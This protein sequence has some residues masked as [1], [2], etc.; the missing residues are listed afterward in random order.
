MVA[1]TSRLRQQLQP[2]QLIPTLTV[3]L[4]IGVLEVVLATSFAALIFSGS[5]AVHV[6][7]AIALMLFGA[8]TIMTLV[9]LLTSLAPAVASVQDSTAAILALIAASITAE[10]P[11]ARPETFLT[12]VA[13]IGASSILAGVIFLVLGRFGLGNLVRFIPYP[14]VGGF[15]AGTGWLL[16][17]GGAG[18]LTGTSLTMA[19]LASFGR[20]DSL[21]KWVP[22]LV[23]AVLLL[24][25]VRRYRHFLVIPGAL[26]AGLALFYAALFVGGSNMLEAETRGWLLGPFPSGSPGW[27][28]WTLEALERADWAHVFAQVAN[29]LTLLVVALLALLLNASGIEQMLKRDGDLNRELQVAGVANAAA[30]LGG[31]IIGFHALSFTA[32]ANRAGAVGRMVSLVG[33]GVCGVVLIVGTEALSLFPRAILGGLLVFL[34]LAFLVEWLY[35]AW[36]KLPRR[37]YLVIVFIVLA[38]A[39]VGLL[40]GVAVGLVAAI[41]LFVIDY[42]RTDVVRHALTGA[43]YQSRVERDP[44]DREILRQLGDE[45]HIL[46][47]QGFVFFGT[48]NS[49]LGRVRERVG[50]PSLPPVRFLVLDFRRVSGLDSSAVLSFTRALQL[51]ESNGFTL[52]LTGLRDPIRSQ[53]ARAGLEEAAGNSLRT[54]PDLDRGSQWC[55]DVVLDSV[56]RTAEA[57]Q[58]LPIQL[59][60]GLGESVDPERLMDYLDPV[61]IPAAHELI[62][63][64]QPSEDLYFLESGRLTAQ[65]TRRDGQ[66]V[67][68]R[69]MG[70]GTVVGEITMYLRTVRTASVV[71]EAPSK[72]Y[73]LT[74]SAFEE[75]ERRDPQLASAL[76]RLFARLLADRL[77][78][79]LL[80]ME[81]LRD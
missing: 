51:A 28:P 17:K 11:G 15:L 43:T 50:D 58:P 55:E 49:L 13:A 67:R 73:R 20:P 61:E 8:T 48:S 45:T 23:F 36:F 26:L 42:S 71:S 27:E 81:A 80:S 38:V 79:A 21:I 29:V 31:G 40:P 75:M 25:L 60:D 76:H 14:V 30:G 7:S 59:Q 1:T 18:V 66:T 2:R 39:A 69:T 68:L 78:D 54:F 52:V 16:F 33:A 46:E 19:S 10:L 4:V 44:R 34:G 35:E 47:L 24:A 5:A 63:Q 22:G 56:A 9:G 6:P 3:G 77:S 37:D 65:F 12:I 57:S 72:L 32:L 74:R 53:L 62:R 70:P 41:V 64:G